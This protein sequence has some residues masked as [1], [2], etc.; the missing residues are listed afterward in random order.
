MYGWLALLAIP[1]YSAGMLLQQAVTDS[2]CIQMGSA[3]ENKHLPVW[4]LPGTP[5]QMVDMTPAAFSSQY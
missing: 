5:P 4:F 3:C 1:A 2:W